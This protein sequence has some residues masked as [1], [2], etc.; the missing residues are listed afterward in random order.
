MYTQAKGEKMLNEK[1]L[2]L[3]AMCVSFLFIMICSKSS[4]LY[5][6]NDWQDVN[7]FFTVGKAM[8]NGKVLYKDIYEQKGPILYFI[9][10]LAYLISQTSF[11][12]VFIIEVFSFGAY[13]YIAA[14][15]AA[16]YIKNKNILYLMM[17]II[18]S[19]ITMSKAFAHGDS[20]EELSLV[21]VMYSLYTVLKNLNA[22]K[23][24]CRY[25]IV[26]NGVCAAIVLWMKFTILGFYIGLVIFVSIWYLEKK[27]IKEW[28]QAMVCFLLG[29]GMVSLIV[30]GYSLIT[31]SIRD[32]F[33]VYFYNNLFLYPIELQENRLMVILKCMQDTIRTNPCF[34]IFV[35]IG[36]IWSVKRTWKECLCIWM[37]FACMV[38]GVYWGGR[39]Y[40]YY[41]LIFS[42]YTVFGVVVVLDEVVEYRIRFISKTIYVKAVA[43]LLCVC[44]MGVNYIMSD[45]TYLLGMKK[46]E[47][48]QHKFAAIIDSVPNSTM[49][50]YGFMDGGFYTAA[51]KIPINKYFCRLNTPLPELEKEQNQYIEG[52]K[53]DFVVTRNASLDEYGIDCTKYELNS[54]ETF[55]YEGN[56][57]TYFL[58]RLR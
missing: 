7:C 27:Y 31:H 32:L 28:F 1:K 51:N 42:A 39:S 6:M 19:L 25:E 21:L 53:V 35:I 26:L 24:M 36:M 5:P 15:C 16:I 57:Y 46:D 55:Y 44:L 8:M 13:I 52:G 45:N 58:Y 48:P 4:F 37:T 3:Y 56:M 9:H 30:F 38:L 29:V 12:G 20:V 2:L 43:A 17:P 49:L 11:L 14:K 22:N 23:K 47:M 50:N 10:G 34:M 33:Q 41:G 40:V 54:E 18:A